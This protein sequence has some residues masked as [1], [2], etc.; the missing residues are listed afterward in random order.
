MIQTQGKQTSS[1]LPQRALGKTKFDSRGAG[2]AAPTLDFILIQIFS[3]S[4]NMAFNISQLLQAAEY[5]DR[6]ERGNFDF[7]KNFF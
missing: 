5:L 2:L 1:R 3:Y 6:R 7:R 4:V